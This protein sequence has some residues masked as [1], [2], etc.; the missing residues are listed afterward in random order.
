MNHLSLVNGFFSM[1]ITMNIAW[2][3]GDL[4]CGQ[5]FKADKDVVKVIALMGNF[6]RLS[7]S[8][9]NLLSTDED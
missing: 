2:I 4:Y 1:G 3:L 6:K 5:L 7:F 8:E 9:C